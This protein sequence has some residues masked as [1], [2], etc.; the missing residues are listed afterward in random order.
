MERVLLAL[1]RGHISRREFVQFAV[2]AG[3]SLTAAKGMI[4][5]SVAAAPTKGGR[6]TIGLG[7]GSTTNS[8]DPATYEDN[9]MLTAGLTIGS[10]LTQVDARGAIAG[11]LAESFEPSDGAKRWA[12]KIHRG[13]TFHNGRRL[14]TADV[15][16]SFRHHMGVNSKSVIKSAVSQIA[17]I[18]SDGYNVIFMLK[19]G[20]ADFPYILREPRLTIMPAT[21]GGG[22]DWQSGNRTGP[23]ILQEFKPG[24]V[25]RAKRNPNYFGAAWFDE[26]EML[27][28]IDGTARL[29]ALLSNRIDFM[30]RCDARILKFLQ[31]KSDIT[32]DQVTGYEHN[33]FAMNVTVPPFNNTDVRNALKFAVDREEILKTVYGGIG[34]IA[35]DDPVAPSVKF[36][37][38]PKPIHSYDPDT[39]RSLLK[40][41]GISALKVEL[42]A[43]DAAFPGAVD[44]ASI[45]KQSAAKADIDLTVIR[46]PNDGYWDNVWMK[47]PFVASVWNG[48]PT[49][50]AVLTIAY[51]ADSTQNET[52]WQNTRF[53]E[54]LIAARSE[55][56]DLKRAAM[57]AEC[58]QLLH[59]D[60]GLINLIFVT[61]VTAHSRRVS[62]GP[63]LP[64]NDMDGFRIAQ[65]WW[66]S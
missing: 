41:A 30:D 11:D 57:Y 17:D 47:K 23:Y 61:F 62:H 37:V 3:V 44:A 63:L 2:T 28:V 9:Y 55:L 6:L 65:R 24:E 4:S 31:Q 10:L 12:I 16:A 38:N 58:Q 39:A 40:K 59:D 33:V 50:D 42:S 51:A 45:F 5:Q 32:I 53:N 54:L 60:G 26:I 7:W 35:N 20:N 1:Q 43:A 48:R 21:D 36:W 34:T 46:E 29:N 56:D 14:T 22:V 27:S 66:S 25:L 52:F 15:V 13:A 49:A 19:S 8:L 18:K 64:D